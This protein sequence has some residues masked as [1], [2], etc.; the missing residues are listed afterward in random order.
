MHT[1]PAVMTAIS[2]LTDKVF[3]QILLNV[4]YKPIAGESSKEDFLAGM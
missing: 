4:V 3:S 1:A 2:L